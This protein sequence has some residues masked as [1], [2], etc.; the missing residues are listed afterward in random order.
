[1]RSENSFAN[2]WK[3]AISA[4]ALMSLLLLTAGSTYALPSSG[5][6]SS[7]EA[8]KVADGRGPTATSTT[9]FHFMAGG[10]C[11]KT[12]GKCVEISGRGTL[13]FYDDIKATGH[14][15]VY[16]Y[17]E[18]SLNSLDYGYKASKVVNANSMRV[19]F[20]T[21]T[22]LGPIDVGVTEGKTPN[23]GLVCVW[24]TLKGVTEGSE[25]LCTNRVLVYIY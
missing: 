14:L 18:Q 10:L 9:F 23:T 1:M 13:Q 4:F 5:L 16:N 17:G 7:P 12:T 21:S 20:K 24:G 3:F 11:S 19:H 15:I 6:A 8:V 25:T 22:A 2:C